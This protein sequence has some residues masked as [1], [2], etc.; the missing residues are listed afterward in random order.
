MFNPE[1]ME[2]QA[3]WCGACSVCSACGACGTCLACLADGPIPDF[4]GAGVGA[5]GGVGIAANL[6][7]W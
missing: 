7:S 3:G 4:E 1:Y 6:A 2:V 5:V